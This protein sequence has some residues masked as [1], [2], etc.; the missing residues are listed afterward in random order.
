MKDNK[1]PHLEEIR[2]LGVNETLESLEK[3]GGLYLPNFFSKE[4]VNSIRSDFSIAESEL[5]NSNNCGMVFYNNQQFVSQ[6]LVHS[7][8]VFDLLTHEVTQKLFTSFMGECV[9]KA[10][11]YYKTGGNGIS[12]WHHDEKNSGYKSL[13]IIII[14]Y[15]SDVNTPEDGAFEYIRGS[16]KFS[17]DL[18]D[19]YFFSNNIKKKHSNEIETVLGGAGTI[20]IADTRVIHRA[21]PH[22]KS[23][24][25]TSLFSQISKLENLIYKERILVNPEFLNETIIKRK[26]IRT[27]LGF[28]LTTAPHIFPPT[29][30]ETMPFNKLVLSNLYLWI[31]RKIINKSFEF[32]PIKVKK[33]I[34]RR[35]GRKVD[36]DAI[37]SK[38]DS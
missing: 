22:A 23:Y 34:R 26:N 5:L 3:Y 31:K 8:T 38:Y 9:L 36:Y 33:I 12:M 1:Q 16:H 32:L 4:T 30:I 25:R 17:T 21:K 28:G 18:K 11:R 14:V 15:L 13:G 6:T 35:I 7:K 10:S 29:S 37:A 24:H 27:F 19:E 2:S 20:I